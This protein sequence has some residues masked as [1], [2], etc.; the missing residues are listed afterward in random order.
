M[1]VIIVKLFIPPCLTKNVIAL[2][3]SYSIRYCMPFCRLIICFRAILSVYVRYISLHS[4]I[5]LIS[6]SYYMT[7]S[8]IPLPGFSSNDRSFSQST[9][10]AKGLSNF[11]KRRTIFTWCRK[12]NSDIIFLQETNST[13]S[14]QLKWKNEWGADLFAPMGAQTL[15]VLQS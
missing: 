12:R 9:L 7:S 5:P 15:E 11:R 13:L 8:I 3:T 1:C 4:A 6:F 10:N 2:E 14:T